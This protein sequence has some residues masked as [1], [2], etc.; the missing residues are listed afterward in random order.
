MKQ[1]THGKINLIGMSLRFVLPIFVALLGY[2]CKMSYDDIRTS[3]KELKLDLKCAQVETAKYYANHLAEHKN[4][5]VVYEKRLTNIEVKVER[6]AVIESKIDK[7]M[8]IR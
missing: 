1:E 7:L 5:E 4:L 2:F 3:I 8:V 6:I